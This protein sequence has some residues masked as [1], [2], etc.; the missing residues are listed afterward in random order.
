M[1]KDM[2]EENVIKTFY[3]F[4]PYMQQAHADGTFDMIFEFTEQ[5]GLELYHT[6]GR[7]KRLIDRR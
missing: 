7:P 2:V 1:P 6:N 5:E 3:K 4:N